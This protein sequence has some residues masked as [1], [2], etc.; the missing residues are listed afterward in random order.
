MEVA[1][2]SIGFI[3]KALYHKITPK[4]AQVQGNFIN[5]NNKYKAEKG[6][7]LSHLNDYVW[8]FKS[9]CKKKYSLCTELKQ[10]NGNFLYLVIIN[11][12]NTLQ[13]RERLASIKTKNKNLQKPIQN[14]TPAS[15]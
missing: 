15:K 13:Y 11:H 2:G 4:S 14:N 12:I 8:S 6:I 3:K 5:K 10:L 1:A 7:L 9:F